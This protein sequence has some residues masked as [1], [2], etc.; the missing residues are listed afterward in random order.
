[1]KNIEKEI[2]IFKQRRVEL[3]T[4]EVT[5]SPAYKRMFPRVLSLMNDNEKKLVE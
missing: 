1:M 5:N 3:F 2:N 4:Q